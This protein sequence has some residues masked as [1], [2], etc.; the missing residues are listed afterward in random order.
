[1]SETARRLYK[2]YTS[3]KDDFEVVAITVRPPLERGYLR[4]SKI[5]LQNAEPSLGTSW[6]AISAIGESRFIHANLNPEQISQ[7]SEV[8]VAALREEG[9]EAAPVEGI[10][11]TSTGL[12]EK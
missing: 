11:V 1:M 4:A 2:V 9:L 3:C 5:A 6:P 10:L 7:A 8:V 12:M